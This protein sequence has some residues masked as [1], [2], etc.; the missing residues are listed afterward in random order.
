MHKILFQ[1]HIKDLHNFPFT[2]GSGCHYVEIWCDIIILKPDP[3]D[4]LKFI[5]NLELK[6]LLLQNQGRTSTVKLQHGYAE[7]EFI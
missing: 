7:T 1:E 4:F 5:P 3:N 6:P 2:W